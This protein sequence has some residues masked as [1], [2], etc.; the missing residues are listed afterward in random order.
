MIPQMNVKK[1]LES[2]LSENYWHPMFRSV[3]WVCLNVVVDGYLY[4]VYYQTMANYPGR[5][6]YYPG[7]I[8]HFVEIQVRNLVLDEVIELLLL[9]LPP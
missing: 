5:V 1:I 8:V 9:R 6:G 3:L 7:W 2:H 4:Q